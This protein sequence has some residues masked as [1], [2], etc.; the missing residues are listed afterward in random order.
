[1][2]YTPFSN[3][4]K[5]T[6]PAKQRKVAWIHKDT[7]EDVKEYAQATGI[8]VAEA[9]QRLISLALNTIKNT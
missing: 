2:M 7:L 9:M 3:E 1:M 5:F 8:S 4:G 6:L